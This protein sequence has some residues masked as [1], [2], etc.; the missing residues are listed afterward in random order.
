MIKWGYPSVA[1]CLSKL[2]VLGSYGFMRWSSPYTCLLHPRA[3]SGCRPFS[4]PT[5]LISKVGQ[6]LGALS[7]FSTPDCSVQC[8]VQIVCGIAYFLIRGSQTKRRF[9]IRLNSCLSV[10]IFGCIFLEDTKE[11]QKQFK[12]KQTNKQ[13]TNKKNT[14]PSMYCFIWWE[15]WVPYWDMNSKTKL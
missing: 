8:S 5:V 14:K 12:K 11:K 3:W 9:F 2:H 6:V 4:K 13:K 10:I 7:V 1:S 15:E